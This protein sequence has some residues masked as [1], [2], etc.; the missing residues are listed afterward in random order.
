MARNCS[1]G[2]SNRRKCEKNWGKQ[3]NLDTWVKTLRKVY[4]ALVQLWI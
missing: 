2:S 4:E 3:V 1:G